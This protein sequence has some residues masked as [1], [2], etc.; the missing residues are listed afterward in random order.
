MSVGEGSRVWV[1]PT[2]EEGALREGPARVKLPAIG[3][4][5][6][7][8]S[9]RS[10]DHNATYSTFY[11]LLDGLPTPRGFPGHRLEPVGIVDILGSLGG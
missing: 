2:E 3:T 5:I 1:T 6:S 7:T 11:V 4:V 8:K 9:H 10:T